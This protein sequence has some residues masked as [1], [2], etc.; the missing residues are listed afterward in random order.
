MHTRKNGNLRYIYPNKQFIF[1]RAVFHFWMELSAFEKC[2]S[3]R[4]NGVE[5]FDQLHCYLVSLVRR[6]FLLI[7]TLQFA[8]YSA[9]TM[10]YHG[11]AVF[12]CKFLPQLHLWNELL[13]YKHWEWAL[14]F[15]T[16][17]SYCGWVFNNSILINSAEKLGSLKDPLTFCPM[18][19]FSGALLLKLC[20]LP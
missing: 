19:I 7:P 15:F 3:S 20:R 11:R 9:E 8:C 12:R 16:Q 10:C 18:R 6:A 17:A 14:E 2:N 4:Q 5:L 13:H 1:N